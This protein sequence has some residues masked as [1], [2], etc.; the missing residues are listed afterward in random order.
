MLLPQITSVK[1]PTEPVTANCQAEPLRVFIRLL[2]QAVSALDPRARIISYSL[3]AAH[4]LGVGLH[5]I[6]MIATYLLQERA[7]GINI[8]A[9]AALRRRTAFCLRYDG[10][11]VF[12]QVVATAARTTQSASRR[13]VEP[14]ARL[15]VRTFRVSV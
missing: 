12:G 1:Q 2:L 5:G 4:L 8:P 11:S 9:R 13:P 10:E 6:Q 15:I 14:A 7:A 3:I